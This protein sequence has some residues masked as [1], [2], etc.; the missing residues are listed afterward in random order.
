MPVKL[1]VPKLIDEDIPS[2]CCVMHSPHLYSS[3]DISGIF[4]RNEYVQA[5]NDLVKFCQGINFRDPEGS[6]GGADM[7]ARSGD[8]SPD[9]DTIMGT[10]AP[11][12]GFSVAPTPFPSNIA[13]PFQSPVPHVKNG[14]IVTGSPGI[15]EYNR[16][17]CVVY[18]THSI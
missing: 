18:L 10:S 15:G 5:V 16:A 9:G 3:P 2:H 8:A 17:S 13:N 12:A 6:N 7:A 4:I 1:G 11:A 14:V